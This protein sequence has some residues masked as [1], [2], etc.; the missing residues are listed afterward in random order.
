[1]WLIGCIGMVEVVVV[2]R[3]DGGH[4]FLSY[5]FLS[6]YLFTFEPIAPA[7]RLSW[8]TL[9]VVGSSPSWRK[10]M[11]YNDIHTKNNVKKNVEPRLERDFVSWCGMVF[12]SH[13]ELRF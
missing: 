9:M 10:Q 12:Q 6:F 3:K 5:F 13:F 1:M 7:G 11:Y 8:G 2:R 4:S